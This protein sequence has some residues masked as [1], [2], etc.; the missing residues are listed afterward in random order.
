[1]P[2]PHL[3]PD[4]PCVVVCSSPEQAKQ[5]LQDHED[6]EAARQDAIARGFGPNVKTTV[7]GWDAEGTPNGWFVETGLTASS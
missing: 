4:D 7:T 2:T 1:M 3:A 6:A 5:L